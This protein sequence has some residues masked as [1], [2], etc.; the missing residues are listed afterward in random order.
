MIPTEILSAEHQNILKAIDLLLKECDQLSSGKELNKDFFEKAIYFI[1]NYADR[2]HHIKEEDILFKE[3]SGDNV[4]MHCNPTSQMLYEHELGREFIK[5]MKKGLENNNKEE[6][7]QNAKSYGQLLKEHIH[8][9]DN[10]LKH[11][12][13]DGRRIFKS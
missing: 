9:E 11:P 6:V 8:K 5:N 7:I 12:K 4:V 1:Q 3:L 10:I 2:F 13:L